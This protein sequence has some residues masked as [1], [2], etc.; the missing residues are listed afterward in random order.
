MTIAVDF[1][2]LFFILAFTI[3]LII[4]YIA[5][6]RLVK[7]LTRNRILQ[8]SVALLLLPLFFL[9]ADFMAMMMI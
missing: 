5:I 7:F 3:A 4:Q 1:L 8:A 2:I 6:L 9:L